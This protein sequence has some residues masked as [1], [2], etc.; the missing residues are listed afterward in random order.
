LNGGGF[1]PLI[2][3]HSL[4]D[5]WITM[6]IENVRTFCNR[7][8]FVPFR[9]HVSD[10]STV[11]V[12]HPEFVLL[13]RWAL[14]VGLDPDATETPERSVRIALMHITKIEEMKPGSGVFAD[15]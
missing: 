14:H 1:A 2:A 7:S 15:G 4:C 13:T 5:N 9:I 10:G 6:D 11:D 3:S 8:P 12:P